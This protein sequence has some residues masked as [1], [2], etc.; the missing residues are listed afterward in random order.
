[1]N[2]IIYQYKPESFNKMNPKADTIDGKSIERQFIIAI[3]YLISPFIIFPLVTAFVIEALNFG[4]GL[5]EETVRPFVNIVFFLL[6]GGSVI[7]ALTK[8]NLGYVVVNK[9]NHI[10]PSISLFLTP[11]LKGGGT[12]FTVYYT[13]FALKFPWEK[14]QDDEIHIEKERHVQ[15]ELF[16]VTIGNTSLEMIISMAWRPHQIFL[17]SF[18]QN[19]SEEDVKKLLKQLEAKA[20]QIIEGYV[21]STRYKNAD[22]VRKDQEN[23]AEYTKG[24]LKIFADYLGIE[25][26]DISFSKCDFSATTQTQMN[27]LKE[28]EVVTKIARKLK[29]LGMDAAQAGVQAAVMANISNAK[30]G[31][32]IIEIKAHEDVVAIAKG[33]SPS[34][35]KIIDKLEKG[36]KKDK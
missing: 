19:G 29:G 11:K 18:L 23:I 13:G 17:S 30:I 36:G 20:H 21:S 9:G 2:V 15:F 26:F 32:H 8:E 22:E 16:T 25:I 31:H 1:M 33:I 10:K 14:I 5:D 6:I 3:F 27:K 24:R 12:R 34:V 35:P 4:F 7:F 28:T